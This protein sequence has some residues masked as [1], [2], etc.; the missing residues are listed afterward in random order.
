MTFCFALLDDHLATPAEPRSRLYTQYLR[1]L[2]CHD[3]A[4]FA[5]MQDEMQQALAAGL[6]ALAL[7]HYELG[8]VMHGLPHRH[9]DEDGPLAEVLLFGRCDR[10]APGEVDAWLSTQL[11]SAPAPAG[12]ARIRA[13]VSQQQFTTAIDRIRDYIAAGDTYQVNYTYRLHFDAYGEPLALYRKLRQRQ[14]VPYGALVCREDG[15]AVLSFSPELFVQHS[16]GMLKAKPMKGTARAA[17]AADADAEALNAQRALALAA[18]DKNRAENLMI[19]DLL[20]NDL[21]RVAVPGSVKVPHL[22]DVRR[23]GQVLQMTSTIRAQLRENATLPEVLGALYPCGSITGAPKRR[24][25]EIINELETTP[26]GLYTGAIGWFEA[27]QAPGLSI[28]DFCLSVPIRTLV[29]QAPQDG[30][31]HG[32][33]RGV[34]GLGAG[35]VH[36]SDADSEYAECQLKARFLT[37]LGHD[38][39]LFETIF[40]T[41]HGARHLDLHLARLRASAIGFDFVFDE[42]AIRAALEHTCGQLPDGPHRVRLELRA[43]GTLEIRHAPLAPLADE[44]KV[45]V[46]AAATDSRDLLLRHKSSARAVYDAAW[47][48]AEARGGFDLLFFNEKDELTE[49]G[50]SNVFVLLDGQWTT[51]PLAA[52]CL[53]G[54]MRSVLLGDPH[55]RAIE[56]TVTRAQLLQAEQIIVCNALRGAVRATLA[57]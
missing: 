16:Q 15:S 18:D 29:L 11:P 25:M 45:F 48:E 54:V 37:G 56:A 8:A 57:I 42:D 52:G 21:G 17:D 24:T 3:A 33:R 22:F 47:Q 4:G 26:R 20:R 28:G 39:T 9:G 1:T 31:Q 30:V 50:R 38:F 10:L 32:V 7:W 55:Y 6:H 40:A 12:V 2:A 19:V 49:G 53:P 5:A 51:P 35:I 46:A 44:V 13:S 14:P 41:R 43:D 34:L 27:P 23:Y 36:D